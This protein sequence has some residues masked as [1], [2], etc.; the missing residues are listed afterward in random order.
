MFVKDYIFL[1][2]TLEEAVVSTTA[3]LIGMIPEGLI[4]L[5]SMVFAISVTRLAK[6]HTRFRALK[7]RNPPA[8]TCSASTRPDSTEGSMIFDE[9]VPFAGHDDAGD[10]GGSAAS[11]RRAHR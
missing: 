3:A 7:R 5:T 11:H 9:L 10:E 8:S 4:M 1:H 6:Y 2:S